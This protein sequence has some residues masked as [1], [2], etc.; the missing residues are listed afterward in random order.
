M[1]S[2]KKPEY[3]NAFILL[4]AEKNQLECLNYLKQ[5]LKNNS[6]RV[7]FSTFSEM[8]N[9]FKNSDECIVDR[10]SR[11]KL[12]YYLELCKQYPNLQSSTNLDTIQISEFLKDL[13]KRQLSLDLVKKLC[14]DFGRN[15]QKM[16]V[17]Q[18]KIVLSQQKLDFEIKTDQL[19]KDEVIVKINSESI[20]KM[21]MVYLNEITDHKLLF[22]ELEKFFVDEVNFYFYEL[23]LVVIDLIEYT[24]ELPSH[25]F[26]YRSVLL[27]LKHNLTMKRRSIETEEYEEW[28]KFNHNSN[29]EGS[30]LP[31]IANYRLPFK[32]LIKSRPENIIGKDLNV[33]AFEV[34]Y[35]LLKIHAEHTSPNICERI[36][37]CTVLAAKNS[38]QDLQ[39]QAESTASLA[40]NL[41]PRNNAFLQAALRMVSYV[42]NKGKI[43]ATLYFILTNTPR[44]GDQMEAAYESWKFAMAHEDEIRA[45]PK[46][47]DL[48]DKVIKKYFMLKSQHLLYLYGVYDDKLIALIENPGM[49]I[50]TLYHHES[51]LTGQKKEINKLCSEL[52]DLHNVDLLSL[53]TK[54][55]RI[56]LSFSDEMTPIN[57]GEDNGEFNETVYEDFM[58]SAATSSGFN[59]NVETKISDENVS[60]AYYVLSSWEN[61][62]SLDFLAG[63]INSQFSD[64]ENQIQLYECFAK[65]ISDDNS[66]YLDIVRPETYLVIRVCYYLKKMGLNF[67]PEVFR[68]FD[69]V[70]LL[71]KIW[72]AHYNNPKGLEIMALICITYNVHLPQ[73]WNGILKQMIAHKM[74]S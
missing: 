41:T 55:L 18:I 65:I 8:Y 50:Q 56:W 7:A 28:M 51:I 43:L 59:S 10:E 68:D 39:I 45:Q 2:Q 29:V 61:E 36:D 5:A 66:N 25:Y 35:Q 47:H 69:K 71:K 57:N 52:A 4:R 27:I 15:Y 40:W 34:Y 16:L 37:L 31:I 38:V 46:Y 33:E 21:C 63:E 62:S 67:K 26:F 64:A 12:F 13:E 48:V 49:L 6:Q 42:S 1:L 30:V 54:L 20:K 72:S 23:Y 22:N 53:Q 73:I 58:G 11:L 74:V 14:T 60:R 70:E 17:R 3:L 9:T 44:G 32:L 24:N 19:G